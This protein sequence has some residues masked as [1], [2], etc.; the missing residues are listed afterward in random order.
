MRNNVNQ[1]VFRFGYDSAGYIYNTEYLDDPNIKSY[2]MKRLH[3]YR[4]V[5]GYAYIIL[6][7]PYNPVLS[8]N[9]YKCLFINGTLSPIAT[10]DSSYNNYD[11]GTIYHPSI[12]LDPI[13]NI[14]Q[15]NIVTVA[16]Y[17]YS[18]ITKYLGKNPIN[19]QISVSWIVMSDGTKRYY[20]K[21]IECT[22][23]N[24]ESPYQ[25]SDAA[26]ADRISNIDD[27]TPT[28]CSRYPEDIQRK[29]VI[30]WIEYIKEKCKISI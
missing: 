25:P 14:E 23:V 9:E 28:L 30:S 3:T 5:C 4:D 18:V 20:V 26:R 17:A 15:A 1:I 8:M 12:E 7:Q 27:C 10:F 24:F 11:Y 2:L 6:I 22:N 21:N 19:L 29:L 13:R 16:K